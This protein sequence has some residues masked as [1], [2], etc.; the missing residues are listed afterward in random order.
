[1]RGAKLRQCEVPQRTTGLWHQLSTTLRW[2]AR[3]DCSGRLM[4]SCISGGFLM[5][6]WLTAKTCYHSR[7]PAK[8]LG[9]RKSCGQ[10]SPLRR[11]EWLR[12]RSGLPI[13]HA[14]LAHQALLVITVECG[15]MGCHASARMT[16]LNIF[17]SSH[18]WPSLDTIA[19][20]LIKATVLHG[21]VSPASTGVGG[22]S[23]FQPLNAG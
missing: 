2:F 23:N 19:S 16:E 22:Y 21:Q 7:P 8:R 6:A 9:G 13:L 18:L 4:P 11:K 15:N 17:S 10:S 12:R 1:M 5:T 14:L 3:V 20:C